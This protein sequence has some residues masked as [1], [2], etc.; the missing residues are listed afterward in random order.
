MARETEGGRCMADVEE[1]TNNSEYRE[2]VSLEYI[3]LNLSIHKFN[4]LDWMQLLWVHQEPRMKWLYNNFIDFEMVRGHIAN[5]NCKIM[6]NMVV[7]RCK[8]IPCEHFG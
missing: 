3:F 2:Q 8:K 7:A 4:S 5:N 6:F 1:A